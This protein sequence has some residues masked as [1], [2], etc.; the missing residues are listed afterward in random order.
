MNLDGEHVSRSNVDNMNGKGDK[1]DSDGNHG[2]NTAHTPYGAVCVRYARVV[3]CGEGDEG[4]GVQRVLL[5]TGVASTQSLLSSEILSFKAARDVAARKNDNGGNGGK[6][7][8]G[9]SRAHN[10]SYS[11]RDGRDERKEREGRDGKGGRGNVKQSATSSAALGVEPVNQAD[12]LEA[13]DSLLNRV[14]LPP[15]LTEKNLLSKI[16]ELEN[17]N[18]QL[19]AKAA[20]ES[21]ML[22]DAKQALSHAS[23]ARR[24]PICESGQVSHVMTPCGHVLCGACVGQLHANRCPFCRKAI[25]AKVRFYLEGEE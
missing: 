18:K 16:V 8:P 22:N 23:N 20:S 12:L 5:K 19:N 3:A 11:K 24:C 9:T 1:S 10:S 4:C 6:R 13:L 25:Q 14:G 17:Q 15:S 21:L 7:T 2:I